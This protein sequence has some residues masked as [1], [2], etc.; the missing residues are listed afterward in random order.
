[1]I[2]FL[3]KIFVL[4]L[5]VKSYNAAYSPGSRILHL[6]SLVNHKLYVAGGS[7]NPPVDFLSDTFY[8]DL[9]SNFTTDNP[10]FITDATTPSLGIRVNSMA[11]AVGGNNNATIFLFGGWQGVR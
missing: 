2:N 11:Y 1:M 8:L 10:Q 7:S 3:Q 6:A 4:F 9:S 5:I